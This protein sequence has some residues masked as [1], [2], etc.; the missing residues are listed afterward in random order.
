MAVPLLVLGVAAGTHLPAIPQ[1]APTLPPGTLPPVALPIDT[2][3]PA[4]PVADE[5]AQAKPKDAKLKELL[6]E[7]LLTAREFA[8]LVTQRV[9]NNEGVPEELM[10]ATRMVFE[11]ELQLSKSDKERVAVLERFLVE[12]KKNERMA[13]NLSNNGQGR[14]STA[15][16]AKAE[17]LRVEID[18][19]RAK[20]KTAVKPAQNGT[21]PE[22][23]QDQAAMA[24]IQAGVKRA[25][26][27]VAE[28]R[29]RRAMAKLAGSK[30]LVVEA[31]AWESYREKQ[32]KVFEE[33]LKLK[34]IEEHLVDEKVANSASAQ[35]RRLAAEANVAE[36]AS[37]VAVEEAR[38]Q[39]AE[40]ECQEADLRAKH[41]KARLRAP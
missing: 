11:A 38:V 8:R 37:Q 24:A 6:E 31:Q 19:E 30:A 22:A 35:A 10:E 34:S 20:T 5:P 33:L 16:K 7:R 40:Q 36:S 4:L 21:T 27:K 23:T 32:L 14:Q 1:D 28:A 18:L 39:I 17:R 9:K 3:N 41:L 25:A 2:A 26:M 13:V 29:L 15:L 12:A